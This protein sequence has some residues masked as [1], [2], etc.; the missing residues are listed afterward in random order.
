MKKYVGSNLM[1]R[2]KAY[3]RLELAPVLVLANGNAAISSE[4]V[5]VVEKASLLFCTK[6]DFT[7]QLNVDTYER[8]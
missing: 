1:V 3:C 6:L 7:L 2:E 8:N 4:E 5:L